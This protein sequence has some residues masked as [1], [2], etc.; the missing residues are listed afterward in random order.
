MQIESRNCIQIFTASNFRDIMPWF[1]TYLEH[2]FSVFSLHPL[3]AT[4]I[5]NIFFFLFS[6]DDVDRQRHRPT[7]VHTRLLCVC[8]CVFEVHFFVH[9][10]AFLI[11]VAAVIVVLKCGC[12]C[13]IF[14]INQK[15]ESHF[16]T[17]IDIHDELLLLLLL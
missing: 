8:V 2:P 16:K 9:L 10:G 13:P 11:A 3:S 7:Y 6:L 14:H 17:P 5:K 15:H 4:R 1:S 12:I